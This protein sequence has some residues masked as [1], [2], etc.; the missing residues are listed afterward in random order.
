M[1]NRIS[2]ALEIT[3]GREPLLDAPGRRISDAERELSPGHTDAA[4]TPSADDNTF[5]S[6]GQDL[7][8][9]A[10]FAGATIT[11]PFQHE[12]SRRHILASPCRAAEL[13]FRPCQLIV[14]MPMAY[15]MPSGFD[16]SATP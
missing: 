3:S 16:A 4:A 9:L 12:D 7:L 2:S 11:P 13:L 5:G 10:D 15:S 8:S 14:M 6:R 1:G